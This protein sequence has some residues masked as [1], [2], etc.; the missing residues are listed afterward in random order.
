MTN[1]HA[2][3]LFAHFHML[4]GRISAK[5]NNKMVYCFVLQNLVVVK[6][7]EQ[8]ALPLFDFAVLIV[9]AASV[10]VAQHRNN[11]RDELNKKG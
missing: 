5:Q 8:M 6:N 10:P 4:C 3:T 2:K 7:L 9:F 11:N 1:L